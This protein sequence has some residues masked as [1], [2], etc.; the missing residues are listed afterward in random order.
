[1][2]Q[3]QSL[4]INSGYGNE[5]KP[6]LPT[7]NDFWFN[8]TPIKPPTASPS[9]SRP[10]TTKSLFSPSPEHTQDD[11]A[12]YMMMTSN[13][14]RETPLDIISKDEKKLTPNKQQ[15]QQQKTI[16]PPQISPQIAKNEP[17]SGSTVD[18]SSL[19]ALSQDTTSAMMNKKRP[20]STIKD[21]LDT[22]LTSGGR[23]EKIRK[24]ETSVKPEV[25]NNRL[26]TQ[27]FENVTNT[28]TPMVPIAKQPIETNPDI[29]KSLLKE[30]FSSTSNKFDP[31]DNDS[32]LDVI[33][34]EPPE[35]LLA[36]PSTLSS[37]ATS[38]AAALINSNGE[39][40]ISI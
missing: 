23:N 17:N 33:N 38:G 35:Q 14:K 16:K 28:S 20:Y 6:P 7:Q 22:S 18:L 12:K 40:K 25:S 24:T 27:L 5:I 29:V 2:K 13:I 31:F 30:C 36:I 21:S 4:M 8:E 32:P 19:T 26:P 39:L 15:Q 37:S 34:S 11:K 9:A 1:M 10:T 3:Q